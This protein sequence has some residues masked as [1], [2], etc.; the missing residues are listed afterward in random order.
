M[1][2][3]RSALSS[4]A[5]PGAI[6]PTPASRAYDTEPAKELTRSGSRGVVSI[7]LPLIYKG[8]VKGFESDELTRRGWRG[9][10]PRRP[11]QKENPAD[12]GQE[13]MRGACFY[14]SS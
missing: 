11:D 12:A 8:E 13:F 14:S 6:A 7:A 10:F 9:A 5:K 3:A 1:C 2:E 4:I